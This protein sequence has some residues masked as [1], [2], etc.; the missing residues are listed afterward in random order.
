MNRSVAQGTHERSV[1]AGIVE[2]I[3][4]CSGWHSLSGRSERSAPSSIRAEECCRCQRPR[5]T[6]DLPVTNRICGPSFTAGGFSSVH[7]L[8]NLGG[9]QEWYVHGCCRR[10]RRRRRRRRGGGVVGGVANQV[11]G[12]GGSAGSVTINDVI[13]RAGRRFRISVGKGGTAGR[14]RVCKRRF[15]WNGRKRRRFELSRCCVCGRWHRRT[16]WSREQQF[17]GPGTRRCG[18]FEPRRN[19]G[20]R[21]RR[22]GKR[23][24][25]GA[26]GVV[27]PVRVA[28]WRWRRPCW[29]R[30]GWKWWRSSR[31]RRHHRAR[32]SHWCHDRSE[33]RNRFDESDLHEWSRGWRR[34][35][36]CAEWSGRRRWP[37]SGGLPRHHWAA[38]LTLR[39][40]TCRLAGWR[41]AY[42][43][44]CFG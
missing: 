31:H 32:W 6:S 43:H 9:A 23:D 30:S 42:S 27:L 13:T 2:S 3:A 33:R 35:R 19:A 40:E 25:R 7:S 5:I 16:W 11:G 36:R 21:V 10:G 12:A 4:G 1:A 28:G 41:L 8:R 26:V 38:V 17:D 44:P 20:T 18:S 34:G 29:V 24:Y 14:G 15:R 22:S 39:C 37:G